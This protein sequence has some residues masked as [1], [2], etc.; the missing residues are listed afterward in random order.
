M[1]AL[2]LSTRLFSLAEDAA[3]PMSLGCF[4]LPHDHRVGPATP[5]NPIALLADPDYP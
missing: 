3:V 2:V 5:T 4:D 1:R